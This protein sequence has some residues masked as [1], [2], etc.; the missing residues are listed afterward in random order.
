MKK[1]L[2][3]LVTIALL[4]VSQPSG[5]GQAIGCDQSS[6][7]LVIAAYAGAM[8]RPEAFP[9]ITRNNSNLYVIGS[10]WQNCIGRLSNALRQSVLAG[11]S[12][13]EIRERAYNIASAANSPQSG[14]PLYQQMMQTNSDMLRLASHLDQ[15]S[16]SIR[17]IF[18]DNFSTYYNSEVYQMSSFIWRAMEDAWSH[19]PAAV[20]RFR[21]LFYQ[22]YAWYLGRLMQAM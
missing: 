8:T 20:E 11:P 13:N 5:F 14:E 18:D 4:I 3:S 7:E 16:V 17:A 21:G 1:S 9:N 22:M 12:P 19:N 10:Q 6:K 15:L 2:L